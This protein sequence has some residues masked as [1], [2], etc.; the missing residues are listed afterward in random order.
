MI[1]NRIS[2]T[3]MTF[4]NL[5]KSGF[6]TQRSKLYGTIDINITRV[7]M[8]IL[9]KGDILKKN[10]GE[11]EFLL[12]LQDIGFDNIKEIVKRSPIFSEMYESL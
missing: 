2:L 5:C 4:T 7:D 10:I 12:A 9:V 6:I 1:E 8:S 11:E 3:E